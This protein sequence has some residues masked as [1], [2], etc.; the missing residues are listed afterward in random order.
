MDNSLTN[1]SVFVKQGEVTFN[2]FE[3]L[4]NS[5]INLA[6]QLSEIIITPETILANKKFIAEVRKRV[7]ILED[8]RKRVKAKLLEPYADFESRVKEIVNIVEVA[9]KD[10]RDRIRKFE[11]QERDEKFNKIEELFNKRIKQYPFAE[12]FTVNDFFQPKYLN[13]G[14]SLSKIEEEL[15]DWLTQLDSEINVI[16]T[17]E[18]SENIL[19]EY[20]NTLNLATAI[21]NVKAKKTVKQN[22]LQMNR[23]ESYYFEV[24]SEEDFEDLCDFM[25]A[26]DIGYKVH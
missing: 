18:D 4:K 6:N 20:T 16:K 21:A 2:S 19:F 10:Y 22:I 3:K 24:F 23:D 14:I 13:K 5:A 8:E 7:T 25:D 1:I 15:V 26:N 11:D 12:W 17:M 9:E